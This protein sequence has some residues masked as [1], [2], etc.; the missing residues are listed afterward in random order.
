MLHEFLNWYFDL[1]QE[2]VCIE[3]YGLNFT[4]TTETTTRKYG[5]PV[6]NE[7]SA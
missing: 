1:K 3:G 5:I 6:T 7:I 4:S 2:A